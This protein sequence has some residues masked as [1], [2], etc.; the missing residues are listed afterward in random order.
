MNVE[1]SARAL[2]QVQEIFD[3]IVRDRPHV[4]VDL[5]V[6]L[7]DATALLSET[8]E[9]GALWRPDQRSDVRFIVVKSY[10]ILYRVGEDRVVI[11]SVRRTPRDTSAGTE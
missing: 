6:R 1:W 5:V 2:D 4:A 3:Y 7:F 8:P 11:A 9:M 10:R